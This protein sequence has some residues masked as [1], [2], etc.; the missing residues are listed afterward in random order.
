MSPGPEAPH[1]HRARCE[2]CGDVLESRHAFEVA[3]CSCGRLSLSG[4]PELRRV[5]WS[6]DPGAAWTDL[7][8]ED[9]ADADDEFESDHEAAVGDD[10]GPEDI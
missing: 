1:R 9:E 3:T 2:V 10:A 6:A 4:G 7:S 8:R 5:R